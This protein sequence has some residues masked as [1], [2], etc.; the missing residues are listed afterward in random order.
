MTPRSTGGTAAAMYGQGNTDC[1][2]TCDYVCHVT[3]CYVNGD[4]GLTLEC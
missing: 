1:D 2:Y 4:R 3:Q